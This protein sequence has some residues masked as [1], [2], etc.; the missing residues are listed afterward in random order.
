MLMTSKAA[1]YHFPHLIVN[2]QVFGP[3]QYV[4]EHDNGYMPSWDNGAF[5]N[6][7]EMRCNKGAQNHAGRVTPYRVIAG[8]DV[9]G[10]QTNLN[11]G[12]GHPGPLTVSPSSYG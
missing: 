8:R 2:G 1:H 7:P 6:N 12:I 10:F 3:M 9:V 11:T 4:R 5:L